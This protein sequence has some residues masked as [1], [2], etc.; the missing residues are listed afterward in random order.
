ML[1]VSQKKSAMYAFLINCRIPALKC[2]NQ[3]LLR[4]ALKQVL[5]VGLVSEISSARNNR[6][7]PQS[8]TIFSFTFLSLSFIIFFQ[9]NEEVENWGPRQNCYLIEADCVTGTAR[10]RQDNKRERIPQRTYS[11]N[12]GN[13]V[14][15]HC[16]LMVDRFPLNIWPS[17][18]G[19]AFIW[20]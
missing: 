19:L 1:S 3:P 15:S 12:W 4:K 10:T 13:L 7:V 17:H 14:K 18:S 6:Y 5:F 20:W 11:F 16:I 2:Y 8:D 9:M